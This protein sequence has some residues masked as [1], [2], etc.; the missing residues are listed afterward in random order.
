MYSSLMN[1]ENNIQWRFA[2]TM[3]K[4]FN[5]EV[6]EIQMLHLVKGRTY[7]QCMLTKISLLYTLYI[8]F[9]CCKNF[10]IVSVPGVQTLNL[11]ML[12]QN[13]GR[14]TITDLR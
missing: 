6:F 7:T 5:K 13:L 3:W 1:I 8:L 10:L 12:T 2:E 11:C 4:E 14:L 9:T